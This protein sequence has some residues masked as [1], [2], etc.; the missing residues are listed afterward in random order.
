[1]NHLKRILLIGMILML[2]FGSVIGIGFAQDE[3]PT[4]EPEM[5]E[6]ALDREVESLDSV[7]E[8]VT[9]E[10]GE[11]ATE[12]E[13]ALFDEALA[14][15][16]ETYIALEALDND[17]VE[18]ALEALARVTGQLEIILAR[19]PELALAPVDTAVATYDLYADLP[20]IEAAVEEVQ[21]LID[22]NDLQ[23]ARVLLNT[24][25]SETIIQTYYIPLE[26]YPDAIV[27]AVALI[28]D[29]AV[30]AGRAV[31]NTALNTLVVEETII[32]LPIVRAEFALEEAELLAENA[33]RS[34][35]EEQQLADL[36]ILAREELEIAELLGYANETDY[37]PLYDQLREIESLT[38]GGQSGTGFFGAI[39]RLLSE[40]RDNLGF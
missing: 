40:L 18:G 32:P 34:E 6:E 13:N 1:M 30:E 39:G 38:E 36:L 35:E 9:N 14:A 10:V 27:E 3:T 8:A 29:G 23:A 19:D 4:P 7:D 22:D 33:D 24:L 25:V 28:D 37:Q 17:D 5:T 15:I 21:S 2:L 31:L 26:T 16:D 11:Q 20:T 12:A